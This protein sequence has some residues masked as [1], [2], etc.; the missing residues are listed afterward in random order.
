M[1]KYSRRDFLSSAGKGLGL[2][3]IAYASIGS[4]LKEIDNAAKPIDHLSPN[5]ISLSVPYLRKIIFIVAM[6]PLVCKR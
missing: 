3:S 6:K 1:G 4:L 5:E 2:A